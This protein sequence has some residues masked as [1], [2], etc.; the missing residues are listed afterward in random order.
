[1][2]IKDLHIKDFGVFQ[3][4]SFDEFEA[5][6]TVV[7]GRNET[8]KTTL[9]HFLRGMLY[10]FASR[11]RSRYLSDRAATAANDFSGGHIDFTD[12]AGV[13]YRFKRSARYSATGGWAEQTLLENG[14]SG[15]DDPNAI[16]RLLGAIDEATFVRIYAIGLTE[17]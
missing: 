2:Y 13:S 11:E 9:M 5:G 7:F 4:A 16:S 6:L 1:M 3:D 10:G 17:L 14:E 15:I 8:G 12:G